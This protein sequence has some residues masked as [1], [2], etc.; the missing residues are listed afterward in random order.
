MATNTDVMLET[1]MNSLMAEFGNAETEKVGE[2]TYEFS[3]RNKTMRD[4]IEF[5]EARQ[6]GADRLYVCKKYGYE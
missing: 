2:N 1:M 6:R 5:L 3:N 4:D